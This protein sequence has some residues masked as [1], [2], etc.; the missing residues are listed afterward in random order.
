M[1]W[2]RM[3]SAEARGPLRIRVYYED[4]DAGGVVYHAAYLRFAERAR[5][6]LM[7]RCGGDHPSLLAQYG[8][9]LAV[10]RCE[11]DYRRPGRLDDLVDVHTIVT[12]VGA[13]RFDMKQRV[14]RDD[15]ILVDLQL[16]LACIGR[17]GRATRLPAPLRGALVRLISAR[18]AP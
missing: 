10:R 9:V 15:D 12:G 2:A 3:T 14:V 13:A 4:T 8:V 18:S 16:R 5:T 11:I 6:E 7:R 17:T 1:I